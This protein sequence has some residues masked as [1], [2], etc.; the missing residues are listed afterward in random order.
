MGSMKKLVEEIRACTIC[1][2]DLPLG[3]NPILRVAANARMAIIGQAPGKK[4]HISGV[5]WQ[6]A[7]GR[8]LRAWLGVDERAFYDSSNF[9]IIPMGFCYPG[10]GQSG[11]LPPRPECAASWHD[12]IHARLKHIELT[13]LVGQYAQ[14]YYLGTEKKRTLTQTVKAYREYYP[15]FMVLPH[16]SPRNRF[17]MAKNPWFAQ[18]VIPFLQQKVRH[19][20]K[21]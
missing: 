18:E 11:D 15:K 5:P 6:D 21:D 1:A 7:S 3:T 4:V 2:A 16:P 17:W 14:S 12:L 10:K 20:L 13:L 19:I 8:N 9:A